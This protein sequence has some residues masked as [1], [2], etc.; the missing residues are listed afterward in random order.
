MLLQADLQDSHP[1][2]GIPWVMCAM[3]S[4][5]LLHV[6]P[7]G[8][9]SSHQ[10]KPDDL[11]LLAGA[12]SGSRPVY[13]RQRGAAVLQRYDVILLKVGEDH[14]DKQTAKCLGYLNFTYT[15]RMGFSP[16]TQHSLTA[17]H[18]LER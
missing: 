9:L 5:D 13:A 12:H 14:E 17:Y 3:Q 16:I 7:A 4:G 18:G 11:L 1:H 15:S 2:A 10:P 8:T 6:R